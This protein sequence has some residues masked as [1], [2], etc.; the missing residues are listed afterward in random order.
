MILFFCL[1]YRLRLIESRYELSHGSEREKFVT[2]EFVLQLYLGFPMYVGKYELDW[3]LDF[4]TQVE[5][6]NKSFCF[7]QKVLLA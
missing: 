6:F 2:T 3:V 1:L 4:L 5:I 7:F